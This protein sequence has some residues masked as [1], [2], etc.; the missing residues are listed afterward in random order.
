[1]SE[2]GA[3]SIT[4]RSQLG[5]GNE[6][7]ALSTRGGGETFIECGERDSFAGFAPQVQAAG[8]LH[9]IACPQ[10]VPD[11]QRLGV[12][13]QL[14]REFDENPGWKIGVEP[15]QRTIALSCR[16]RS[17]AFASGKRRGDFNRRESTRCNGPGPE[18]PANTGAAR[19]LDVAFR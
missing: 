4:S 5:K 6:R 18:L 13:G 10:A 16:E 15:L 14:R 12:G 19:F 8:E 2:G 17:L 1:L 7:Q 3:W 11:E 9:G